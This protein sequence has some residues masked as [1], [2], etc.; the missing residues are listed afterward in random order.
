MIYDLE[1]QVRRGLSPSRLE[2]KADNERKEHR[3][4][5]SRIIILLLVQ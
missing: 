2:G 5:L 4:K 3:E 1:S